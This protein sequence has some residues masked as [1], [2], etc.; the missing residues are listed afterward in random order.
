[1]NTHIEELR[2]APISA[3]NLSHNFKQKVAAEGYHTLNEIMNLPLVK[4]L[5]MKWFDKGMLEELGEFM[6]NNRNRD[7]DSK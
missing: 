1:M 7:I 4:L 2:S 5:T 6:Y 3:L